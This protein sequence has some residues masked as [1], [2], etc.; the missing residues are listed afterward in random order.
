M[1]TLFIMAKRTRR[2]KDAHPFNLGKVLAYDVPFHLNDSGSAHR[3]P[4]R[5]ISIPGKNYT[6]RTGYENLWIIQMRYFMAVVLYTIKT[7]LGFS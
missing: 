2:L 3:Y 4:H 1:V 5:V 7:V 6:I